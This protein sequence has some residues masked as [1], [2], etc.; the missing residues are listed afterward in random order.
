MH[1]RAGLCRG[2][3]RGQLRHTGSRSDGRQTGLNNLTA[4]AAEA[5]YVEPT[6]P[7]AYVIMGPLHLGRLEAGLFRGF[8]IQNLPIDRV[9]T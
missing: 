7:A 1:G 3:R 6:G 9:R 2:R 5:R 4:V 8:N